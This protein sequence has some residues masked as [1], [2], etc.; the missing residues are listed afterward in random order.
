MTDIPATL[1]AA[2]DTIVSSIDEDTRAFILNP[3]NNAGAAHMG[4]GMA[5][6]NQWGLWHDSVL[7]QHFKTRFGLGHADDMSAI[8]LEAAFAKVREQPH[9]VDAQV[10]RYKSHWRRM[11]VDP[12]SQEQVA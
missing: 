12:L 1:E 5:M 2:V 7:A 3:A 9:D 8:I 4:G 10:E 6:R 11:G